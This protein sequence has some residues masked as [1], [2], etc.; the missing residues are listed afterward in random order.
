MIDKKMIVGM[1]LGVAI[2]GG[3]FW[4][5]QQSNATGAARPVSEVRVVQPKSA[6]QSA[7][8]DAPASSPAVKS[9][10]LT[11][12][13]PEGWKDVGADGM[14][15][16][17]FRIGPGDEAE[18][19]ATI[20]KGTGGGVAMNV[21]RWRG[22]MG[23]PEVSQEDIDALPQISM[24]GAKAV[25]VDL[26]GTYGGM[27]DDA[28]TDANAQQGFALMGA[29]AVREHDAIF[30]KM[31]GPEELLKNQRDNFVALAASLNENN[32][33]CPHHSDSQSDQ[34]KTEQ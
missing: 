29:I 16:A 28:H 27:Q 13:T 31:T 2:A 22:Q 6:N 24:L 11:W 32:G 9:P 4:L 5:F 23:L 34:M 7:D 25:F 18:C 20:L 8:A 10:S 30:L 17:N 19:Y 12:D 26:A 14:R 1:L 15:V 21:N 33:A 3:G